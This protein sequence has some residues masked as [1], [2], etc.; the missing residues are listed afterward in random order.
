MSVIDAILAT[1]WAIEPAALRAIVDL[2]DRNEVDAGEIE[3]YFHRRAAE[4]KAVSLFDAVQVDR[5][6]RLEGTRSVTV[7]DGVAILSIAGPIFPRANMLTQFSGAAS[8]QILALELE[9]ALVSPNVSAILLEVDSPGGAVPGIS[10]FA[11]QIFAARARKPVVA[12][13]DGIAASAAYWLASAAAEVVSSDVGVLGSIGVV[14]TAEFQETPDGRG[15]RQVE[16]VSTNA[17]NK[18][19]DPRTAD[20]LATITA[21]LDAIEGVFVG[22]VARHRGV[23]VETVLSDFGQGGVFVGSEAVEAGLADRIDNFENVLA[24]LAQRGTGQTNLAP[25]AG[26]PKQGV[27]AMEM[28]DLTVETIVDQRADLAAVLRAQGAEEA[29]EAATAAAAGVA[30]ANLAQAREEG[31]AEAGVAERERILAIQAAALPGQGDL[32]SAAIADGSTFEA[33]TA[34]FLAEAKAKGQKVLDTRILDDKTI[35]DLPVQPTASG[36]GPAPVEADDGEGEFDPEKAE[37]DWSASKDLRAEYGGNKEQ[38][39]AYRRAVDTG[40]VRELR[41]RA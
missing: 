5:G 18:R 9:A 1:Q 32:V 7:R 24:A 4:P 6:A 26:R 27:V 20:G 11:D 36:D 34:A 40:R 10:E 17:G 28:S 21:T 3:Q 19:P 14:T 30:E 12:Y 37:R 29:R 15:R 22:A 38:F 39:I 23:S 33:A 31:Q 13:V 41:Q 35:G 2:A 8:V 25:S 16:I